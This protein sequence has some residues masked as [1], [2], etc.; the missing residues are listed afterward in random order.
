MAVVNGEL[1]EYLIKKEKKSQRTE[2]MKPKVR[3]LK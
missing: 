2:M 3:E 1:T